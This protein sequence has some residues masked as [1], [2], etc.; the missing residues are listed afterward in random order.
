MG[1]KP[2]M[3]MSVVANAIAKMGV[4]F[5]IVKQVL[6]WC[7]CEALSL[8]LSLSMVVSDVVGR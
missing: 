7:L 3:L 1:E 5:V 8:S 2:F 6:V 4:N